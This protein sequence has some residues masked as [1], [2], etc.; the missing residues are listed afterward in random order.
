MCATSSDV[1]RRLPIRSDDR[2][3]KPVRT[4]FPDIA[5]QGFYGLLDQVRATG[6]R[7]VA[8]AAPVRYRARSELDVPEAAEAAFGRAWA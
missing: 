2:V 8:H 4:A 3:G 5:G 7:M 1:R 6:E